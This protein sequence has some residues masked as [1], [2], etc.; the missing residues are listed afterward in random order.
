LNAI[1][2]ADQ[3]TGRPSNHKKTALSLFCVSFDWMPS[4]AIATK[5]T[6]WRFDIVLGSGEEQHQEVGLRELSGRIEMIGVIARG[7]PAAPSR[8]TPD[9]A[10]RDASDDGSKYSG[11]PA[12]RLSVMGTTF[13]SERSGARYPHD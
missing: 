3:M 8:S 1:R 2:S 13:A 10:T 9:S 4:R 11:A 12:S 6:E 7:L 5:R